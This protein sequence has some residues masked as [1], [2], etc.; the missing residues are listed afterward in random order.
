MK[1]HLNG[2]V[3]AGFERVAAAFQTNFEQRGEIGAACCAYYRGE[4]VVD[5]WGGLRD[6]KQKLPWEE[7]TLILV[8]ST[9]KGIASM[10]IALAHS[11]GL[12]DFDERVAHYWPEFA[13][14]GKE[15]ISVRQLLSHQAGLPVIDQ[16]LKY[17]DFVD[18]NRIANII[19]AQTPLWEPG[20]KHGYHGI[21]LGW[22]ES[23]LIRR[24]DPKQRRLGAFFAEEIAAKLDLEFYIGLPKEIPDSRIA[25]LKPLAIWKMIFNMDK[26]PPEF[27][28][29]M[30]RPW[31]NTSKTFS[32][33]AVFRNLNNLNKRQW[34][35]IELPAANGVGQVRS[36]AKAYSEFA[37]GG[38]VLGIRDE[39]FA[40]LFPPAQTPP[41][42][43]KDVIL[44]FDTA[45]SLGYCKPAPG[46]Q[47]GSSTHT[48]GT[49][50]AGGSFAFA[51]PDKEL[52]FAY[53]MNR[54]GYYLI[55]DPREKALRDAVYESVAGLVESQESVTSS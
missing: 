19:A 18:P 43:A 30:M 14:N 48:F 55:D 54:M 49:P 38:K 51:D 26:L 5:L 35:E 36:I 37:T 28:K 50:G 24:V 16:K 4:K 44:R 41:A 17:E 11:R 45:F 25:R 2:Y 22:Y 3:V 20:T 8:F 39:T 53:A 27:A 34:Q 21:S 29:Q 6:H 1:K 9:T 46:M 15:N 23:E 33:P 7:D 12:I 13:Q 52:S 32:N 47:F 42:G 31:S 40:A 10:S